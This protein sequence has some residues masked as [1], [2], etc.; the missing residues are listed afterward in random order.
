[1]PVIGTSRK[2]KE[3]EQKPGPSDYNTLQADRTLKRDIK[4][5]IGR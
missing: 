5:S 4:I 2:P 1:M 3:I